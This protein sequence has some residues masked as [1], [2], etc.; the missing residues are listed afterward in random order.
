MEK[1]AIKIKSDSD[2]NF[3]TKYCHD[4]KYFWDDGKP[5]NDLKPE[6]FAPKINTYPYYAHFNYWVDGI[7]AISKNPYLELKGWCKECSKEKF[8]FIQ[9]NKF[10]EINDMEND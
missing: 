10:K 6:V 5:V 7:V 4:N 3:I 8:Y 1:F 2:C 9:D